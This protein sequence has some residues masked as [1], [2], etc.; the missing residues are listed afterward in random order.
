MILFKGLSLKHEL[1]DRLIE[2]WMK[3]TQHF[4]A[5][6]ISDIIKFSINLLKYFATLN[7]DYSFVNVTCPG[8]SSPYELGLNMAILGI[9]TVF[10]GSDIQVFKL[11]SYNAYLQIKARLMTRSLYLKWNLSNRGQN[12]SYPVYKGLYS[13]VIAIFV[14]GIE[15]LGRVDVFQNFTAVYHVFGD[16]GKLHQ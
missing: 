4:Q 1:F 13:F 6:W 14:F 16:F 15:N 7:I 10:I 3:F 8:A 2:F 12:I 9:V 5:P 11:V